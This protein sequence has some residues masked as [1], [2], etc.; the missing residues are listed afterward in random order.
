MLFSG[1]NT[2]LCT[3][4]NQRQQILDK[5]MRRI[6]Y[7]ILAIVLFGSCSRGDQMRLQLERL[8]QDNRNDSVMR[9]DSLAE[10]LTDYFDAHGSANEQMRAYYILGR[11]YFDLGELP[12]ALETYYKAADCADTARADCNYRTLSRVHAQAARV[13]NLQ[14]QPRSQLHELRRAQYYAKKG[15]DTLMAVECYANMASAYRLLHLAD[16]VVLIEESA[17][18]I[19]QGMNMQQ[20][21]AQMLSGS[22]TSLVK[23]GDYNKAKRFADIYETSSG[24]FDKNGT[25]KKGREIYYYIKG[26]Y[27]LAAN[28]LDS[29]EYLFRKLLREGRT[30]NHQIA[31]NKGLQEVYAH[32]DIP[33]SIAK[34]AKQSYELNDSAYSLSEMENIQKFQA[35]YNYNH[36]KLLAEQQKRKADNAYLIITVIIALIVVLSLISMYFLL[37][38]KKKE[39]NKQAQYR[40]DIEELERTQT[41]LMQLRSA[42]RLEAE[43]LIEEKN[44]ALETLQNKVATQKKIL[45]SHM[46]TTERMLDDSD[47]VK[48]L[49]DL[50]EQNPPQEASQKD[51]RDLRQF[52]NEAI[53]SFFST[54]N[55]PDSSLRLIEYDVCLLIRFHFKP[56]EICKLTGRSDSYISNL[57]KG[58]LMKVYGVK[59]SP[60]DCDQRILQIK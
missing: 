51:F 35:S 6:A 49:R 3:T 44:K 55:T 52:A 17:S 8:E 14:I 13:F 10:S 41:E 11:T 43:M 32:R 50:L 22:I 57:R 48:H 26:E 46:P 19:F 53:P 36:N 40:H 47:V 31:A 1:N 16:S 9:N 25:I 58:I 28:E 4:V 23:K 38:Y 27:Y 21:A 59:G 20:R 33:D 60:K 24:F 42:E 45:D 56:A 15:G 18:K 12:R 30:L 54:L 34:Y 2:Y 7:F 29:A 5:A 37:E 39:E